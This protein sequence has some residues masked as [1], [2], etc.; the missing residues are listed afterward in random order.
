[1]P[2]G[3][4]GSEGLNRFH[5]GD[6]RGDR[7]RS[8]AIRRLPSS[9]PDFTNEAGIEGTVRYLRNIMGLWLLQE[10]VC[11]WQADLPPL[12]TAAADLPPLR[13]VIDAADP[14]FPA[15][16][17]MP[18]RI[19]E[20]CRTTGQAVPGTPPEIT[21]CILDSL[22]LAHRRAVDD[23]QRLADHPVDV[24]HLV[25]GGVRNPLLCQLTADARGLPVI[26][27]PPEA[28]ALRNVLVQ[29]RALGVVGDRAEMRSLLA[30]T[31]PLTRYEPTGDRTAWDDAAA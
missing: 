1:M 16:G 18:D 9:N 17:H 14:A 31:Q 5:Q 6:D 24:V 10:C 4:G 13:S 19:R 23:A 20:A 22:V 30:R 12:L 21:R 28:A 26:A 15:P 29:A 2:P 25:G 8:S 7:R 27:G 11:E 3:V